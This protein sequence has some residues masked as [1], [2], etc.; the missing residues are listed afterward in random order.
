MRILLLS[1][2]TGGGHNAAAE[3]LIA[4]FAQRNIECVKKDTL[5]F[6]SEIHSEIISSG[7]SY[8]YRHLPQL[9]GA[10]YR[11]EEK[12]PPKF[13]YEQMAWGSKNFAN[14]L[15]TERFDAIISTHIFGSMMVTEARKNHGVTLPHYVVVTDYAV[16]PG[17]DMV[18]VERYFIASEELTDAYR[19]VGISDQRICPSGIPIH[20]NFMCLKSKQEARKLLHL[21]AAGKVVLLFSGSIGCGHLERVAPELEKQLPDDGTLIIICGHNSRLYKQLKSVVSDKTVVIG[22]T[23]RIADYMAAADLCI[24]KPGGLSSTEMLVSALP[25]VL[26]LSVPGCETRNLNF[27]LEHKAAVGTDQWDEAI[28]LTGFLLRNP[29]K[30]AEIKENLKA[31]GYPGGASF[32]VDTVMGD[33]SR[34]YADSE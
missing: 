10:G 23:T 25:S 11:F 19:A 31:I 28:R 17:T 32:I 33:I 26:M 4:S 3:A 5:A 7:H 24:S 15:K 6:I 1:A 14:Y 22:F 34:Q 12:H 18:D 2:N 20:P 27:F 13:I 21:P 9:F 16:Y 30:A 8:I 29:E